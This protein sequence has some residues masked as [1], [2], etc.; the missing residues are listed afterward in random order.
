MT[1]QDKIGQEQKANAGCALTKTVC[2][3]NRNCSFNWHLPAVSHRGCNLQGTLREELS[4][5]LLALRG[6]LLA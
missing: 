3:Y 6:H 5:F 1:G 2:G 4:S